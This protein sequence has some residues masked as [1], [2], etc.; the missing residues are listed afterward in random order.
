[1]RIRVGSR[2]RVSSSLQ[3]VSVLHMHR[4]AWD[5]WDPLQARNGLVPC[6]KDSEGAASPILMMTLMFS[7]LHEGAMKVPHPQHSL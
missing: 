3:G 4:M 5:E 1:M 2:V 6:M 7:S